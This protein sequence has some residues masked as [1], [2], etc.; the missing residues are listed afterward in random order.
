MINHTLTWVVDQIAQDQSLS[1]QLLL[2]MMEIPP[3]FHKGDRAIPCFRFAKE[4]KCSPDQIAKQWK[5]LL[6]QKGLPDALE[7]VEAAGGYLN[8]FFRPEFLAK[9]VLTSIHNDPAHYG[10]EKKDKRPIVVLEFSSPNIAKPFSIGHLRSTNLGACLSRIFEAR[11]WKVVKINHLGDWGTQFGK[12]IAAYRRWG[13][14][15]QLGQ[16]PIRS[17]FRL[18]VK[19]HE[20]E[21]KDAT[22]LQEARENFAKLEQK[23]S[24]AQEL[25]QWFRDMTLKELKT[26]YDKL[27]IEFDYYWGESFY[28]DQIQGLI[29]ELE[30]KHIATESE[31]ALVV[32]LKDENRGMALLRKAD[33]S[34]LYL[35]RDLAAAIYRHQQFHFD[36][37]IYVVGSEQQL[38]FQQL[39]SILQ[40]MGHGWAKQ[41]EHVNFGQISFGDERMSTRKGNVV[42]LSDVLE[43]ATAMAK[44]IV[45]E[46][47]PQ[48]ENIDE[49]AQQV[50]LGAVLFADLSARR[51]KSV[52]FSWEDILSFDG[53]TGPYL[54]YAYV[55][56]CSL[57]SR[58]DK[59]VELIEDFHAIST[60]EE[61]QLIRKLSHFEHALKKAEREREPFVLGQYLI[62]LTKTFN[63]FYQAVRILDTESEQLKARI[64]L[65]Y[66]TSKVLESGMNI[67][68]IPRPEKM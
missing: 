66:A 34:S 58:Y 56:T 41:C 49:V 44:S 21:D 25:W 31:G 61:Q 40:K 22:L 54:Q 43:R 60:V 51:T 53:E 24:E 18:Y 11:G 28:M 63:R 4:K 7:K 6:E 64:L 42:F 35:T 52:K 15:D 13:K 30:T 27:S 68:G 12:L 2:T 19:F 48:L 32:D 16:D 8:L 59:D 46:K 9:Q 5:A 45:L 1:S 37:M 33:D 62:D 17:L 50:G 38:H 3:D 36:Q 65:V 10:F 55:R 57:L 20:E 14:A 47:N 67:L 29:Q 26:L 39:F 23:D